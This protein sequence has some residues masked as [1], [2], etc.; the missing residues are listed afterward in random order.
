MPGWVYPGWPWR[1]PVYEGPGPVYNE[2]QPGIMRPGKYNGPR[3]NNI[4]L[5]LSLGKEAISWK[6]W[7]TAKLSVFSL[8]SR[9]WPD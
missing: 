1:V 2:A 3:I 6:T 9:F 5:R 8:F 4:V 7:K